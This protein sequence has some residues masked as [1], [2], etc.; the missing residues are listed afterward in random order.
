MVGCLL[1]L[2]SIVIHE[3]VNILRILPQRLRCFL[4]VFSSIASEEYKSFSQLSVSI[5]S[6][7]AILN[8]ESISGKL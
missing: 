2:F 6:F 7:R 1:I 4:N 8:F 5:H 3:D